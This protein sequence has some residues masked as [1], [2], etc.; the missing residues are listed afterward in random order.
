LKEWGRGEMG[1]TA[2]RRLH[3]LCSQALEE[4]DPNKLIVLLTEINDILTGVL[5]E[6]NRVL[7]KCEYP[8]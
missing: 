2:Q 5:S 3:D 8:A 1:A 7:Q 4:E 6:V